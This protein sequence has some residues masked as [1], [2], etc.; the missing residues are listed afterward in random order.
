[1]TIKII[2]ITREQATEFNEVFPEY[3]YV[4]GNDPEVDLLVYRVH[5]IISMNN[6]SLIIQ[7][8]DLNN[9]IGDSFSLS[10]SDYYKIEIL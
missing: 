10:Y 9:Q 1:M 2:D 7:L 4:R 3:T 8:L 5:S 6:D